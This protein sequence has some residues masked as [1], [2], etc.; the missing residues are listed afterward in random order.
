[1]KKIHI[2]DKKRF[3]LFTLVL[4]AVLGGI[5][6]GVYEIIKW[7]KGPADPYEMSLTD[8]GK[9]GEAKTYQLMIKI[10][11]PKGNA[12][13]GYE[14]GDII[15]SA[16]EDKE[17]SLA[18]KEGFLIVKMKITEAQAGLLT[19]SKENPAEREKDPEKRSGAENVPLRRFTVDLAK[20]GIA[21]DDEK[22]RVIVDKVFEWKET[23][24]EKK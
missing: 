17:W 6:F 8:A 4:L 13:G 16:P 14:R 21:D 10:D 11:R 22:G 2:V 9:E 20:L 3:A 1:M 7:A 18:E 19:Q 5:G 15:L 24:R 23:V 12:S